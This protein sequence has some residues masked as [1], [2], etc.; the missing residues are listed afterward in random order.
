VKLLLFAAALVAVVAVA[1]GSAPDVLSQAPP[2]SCEGLTI[3][4]PVA[5]PWVVVPAPAGGAIGA[6]AVWQLTCPDGVVGGLDARV[7]N[8][9]VSLSFSGHIG[10]PVNPGITTRRAVS[11]TGYS[12]GPPGRASSFIPFIGCIPAQGGS[13]TPTGLARATPFRPGDPVVRRVAVLGMRG[14]RAHIVQTC[15]AGERLLSAQTSIG[16]YLA[17]QPTKTQLRAVQVTKSVRGGK[18]FVTATRH[19]LPRLTQVEVQ[20]HALCASRT[21]Q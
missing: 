3:C 15:K 9:W 7:A 13:R 11:F 4:V 21:G 2:G 20:V 8:P 18:I 1:A 14:P 12:V 17:I 6:Q 5:G 10:S 19:G 16:I